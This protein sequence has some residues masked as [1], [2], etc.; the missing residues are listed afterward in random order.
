M[1][2]KNVQMRRDFMKQNSSVASMKLSQSLKTPIF[3]FCL[4]VLSI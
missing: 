3:L 1:I 4:S 2:A